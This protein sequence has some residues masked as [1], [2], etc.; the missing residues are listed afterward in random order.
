MGVRKIAFYSHDAQGLGHIRRNLQLAQRLIAADPELDVLLICASREVAHFQIPRGIDTLVLPGI[1]KLNSGAYVP[2]TSNQSLADT[3]R[4][5]A[6]VIR[7]ALCEFR[8]DLFVVDKHPFGF[9]G[10]LRSSLEALHTASSTLVLG[11]RDIMDDPWVAQSEWQ[12]AEGSLA[13]NAFYD[14]VWVYGDRTIFDPTEALNLPESQRRKLFFTGYLNPLDSLVAREQPQQSI[15]CNDTLLDRQYCLCLLGGGQD[16]FEV[17]EAFAQADF[18]EARCGVIV[19]GPFMEPAARKRIKQMS[20]SRQDLY[21]RDVVPSIVPLLEH[22]QRVVSLGGY[23]TVCEILSLGI[24]ALIVPRVRPRIEQLIR[25]ELMQRCG[26][27][28][29]LHPDRLTP[30]AMSRWLNSP[31]PP[32]NSASVRLD[33]NGYQRVVQRVTS[34]LHD[35]SPQVPQVQAQGH[36]LPQMR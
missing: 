23:N 34:L 24:P 17:A 9:Q 19:L 27:I 31:L 26:L 6:G 14:E 8:P 22:A 12:K 16:G 28:D 30:E 10:E 13:L 33:F 32:R 3:L 18:G 20:A 35:H 7:A 11:L 2:R 29:L 1:R 5:R 15:R 36:P 4:L 25:A 21:V